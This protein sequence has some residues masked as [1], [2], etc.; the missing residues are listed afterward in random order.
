[1]Y[2]YIYIYTQTILS[3]KRLP[4]VAK[5]FAFARYPAKAG[6]CQISGKIRLL[7]D[8]P[9]KLWKMN[10]FCQMGCFCQMSF[11]VR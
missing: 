6:F 10:C 7:P 1:M 11:F 5:P 4:H 2:I 3:G 9:A 8:H